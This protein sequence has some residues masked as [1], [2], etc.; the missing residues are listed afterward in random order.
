V[1]ELDLWL[2]SKG[3]TICKAGLATAG[4][5]TT[6]DLANLEPALVREALAAVD[7][8]TRSKL[9]TAIDTIVL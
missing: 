3:L 1:S 8:T 2:D 6:I 5:K 4:A 9:M 7:K